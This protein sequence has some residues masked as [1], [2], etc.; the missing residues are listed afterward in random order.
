MALLLFFKSRV[1]LF[2]AAVG[3]GYI[4]GQAVGYAVK[5]YRDE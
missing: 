2:C 4:I 3:A 5:A 1:A